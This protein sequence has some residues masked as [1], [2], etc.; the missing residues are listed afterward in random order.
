ME[1]KEKLKYLNVCF[2]SP[3][4][5]S[6]LVGVFLTL[7]L[8][9]GT[10]KIIFAALHVIETKCSKDSS[11]HKYYA[12]IFFDS[13]SI[14]FFVLFRLYM[15][16]IVYQMSKV[17]WFECK[18]IQ[19]IEC[20]SPPCKQKRLYG[21][22]QISLCGEV[23]RHGNA[24]QKD[25]SDQQRAQKKFKDE[26][27]MYHVRGKKARY[28]MSP[29]VGWFLTPWIRFLVLSSVDPHFLLAPWA[30]ENFDIPPF[31]RTC[32]LCK[33]TF[34]TFLLLVQYAFVLKIDQYHKDY[35][36]AM[37]RRIVDEEET[38]DYL[39]QAQQL[40]IEERDDYNFY[41]TFL[42]INP[43]ISVNGPFYITFFLLGIVLTASD[44]L[45]YNKNIT[46]AVTLQQSS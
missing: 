19:N 14:Y 46:P 13:F 33:I 16:Y 32:Y 43:R 38:L 36:V 23:N 44:K 39:V 18:D 4:Y 26:I 34:Q 7:L 9:V 20:N 24:E 29:F 5:W 1:K 22:M 41:P 12:F 17:W 10:T 35:Y 28:L 8:L 27:D 31:S 11:V 40:V 6:V 30:D 25:I 3:V 15:L 45:L 2:F 21:S 42:S 37:K